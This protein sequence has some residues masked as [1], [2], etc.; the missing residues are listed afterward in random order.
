[1]Y[2]IK[3]RLFKNYI[4]NCGCFKL[5]N[6]VTYIGTLIIIQPHSCLHF[7]AEDSTNY[8][9][10]I[11]IYFYYIKLIYHSPIKS[12]DKF[13]LSSTGTKTL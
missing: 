6:T 7:V 1:M 12:R 8:I 13:K 4:L 2:R 11:F 3:A 9:C 10:N 5:Y